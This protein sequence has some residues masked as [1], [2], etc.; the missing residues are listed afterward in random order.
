MSY[1]ISHGKLTL[2]GW[3]MWD[4]HWVLSEFKVNCGLWEQ[5]LGLGLPCPPMLLLFSWPLS[6]CFTPRHPGHFGVVEL[7]VSAVSCTQQ[8][9]CPSPRPRWTIVQHHVSTVTQIPPPA[10]WHSPVCGSYGAGAPA[11]CL[12]LFTHPSFPRSCEWLRGKRC[13]YP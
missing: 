7:C 3:E 11:C 9:Y 1:F 4:V 5:G 2:L 8:A 10:K 13:A 12:C 6:S